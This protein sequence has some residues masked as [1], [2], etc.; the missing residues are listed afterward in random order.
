VD[1]RE[2]GQHT[3]HQ[4]DAALNELCKKELL[5]GGMVEEQLQAA[6]SAMMQGDSAQA[7]QVIERDRR[8]N[9]LE[10]VVDEDC[11]LVLTRRS[12]VASALR[13][14]FAVVKSITDLERMGDEA[15]RIARMAVTSAERGV[16]LR[17]HNQLKHR[18]QHV[19]SMLHN[20]LDA[21][22]RLY[23]ELAASIFGKD[24]NVDREY[25]SLTRELS[26]FM[27]EDPRS[28]PSALEVLFS[29][30]ALERIG[31]HACTIAEHTIYLTHGTD[32]RHG[33]REQFLEEVG[34][35]S[36]KG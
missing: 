4:F 20:S 23:I 25:E 28:I 31:D 14:V 6:V 18:A 26:T 2:L 22:A 36:A 9:E 7:E 16:S 1:A 12:P 29:A 3:L 11:T 17:Q 32:I 21:F 24:E 19:R 30:R 35:D 15:A 27:M 10:L 8:I 33:G 13:L 34:L 5:T